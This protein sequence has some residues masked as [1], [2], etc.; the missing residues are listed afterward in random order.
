MFVY[1]TQ[2]DLCS[3]SWNHDPENSSRQKYGVTVKL[4]L[5]ATVEGKSDPSSSIMT[6]SESSTVTLPGIRGIQPC[7][8][9]L[10]TPVFAVH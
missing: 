9:L 8:Y 5:F 3:L 10:S 7:I 4:T 2:Q 6:I 1:S